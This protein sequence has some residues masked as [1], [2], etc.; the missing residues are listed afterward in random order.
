MQYTVQYWKTFSRGQLHKQLQDYLDMLAMIS[1][2][3]LLVHTSDRI[4]TT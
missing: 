1:L 3:I 4:L 2:F